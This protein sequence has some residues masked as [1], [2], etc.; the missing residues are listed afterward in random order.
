[1]IRS[2][3]APGSP[4]CPFAVEVGKLMV[5]RAGRCRGR[6]RPR[7]PGG[8]RRAASR[9]PVL[10]PR[11]DRAALDEGDPCDTRGGAAPGPGPGRSYGR[12]P[13]RGLRDDFCRTV[14]GLAARR[15]SCAR[16]PLLVTAAANSSSRAHPEHPVVWLLGQGGRATVAST[17]RRSPSSWPALLRSRPAGSR[18]V[19]SCRLVLPS[20]TRVEPLGATAGRPIPFSMPRAEPV[21]SS[22]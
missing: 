2:L 15:R 6:F 18:V 10:R 22:R 1:M 5:R 12:I 11:T 19:A 20:S 16:V 17:A 21:A 13:D 7:W 14:A 9:Q 3:P 4:V 8:R